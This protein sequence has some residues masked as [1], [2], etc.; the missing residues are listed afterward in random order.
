MGGMST[1]QTPH[2]T[3]KQHTGDDRGL[4]DGIKESL[5]VDAVED[6]VGFRLDRGRARQ[7]FEQ[8]HLSEVVTFYKSVDD[9][10]CP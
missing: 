2:D 7:P 9:Q 1:S 6:G 3:A 8:S 4:G 5:P 10:S